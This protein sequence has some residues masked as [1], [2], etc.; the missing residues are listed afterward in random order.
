[1]HYW[2]D[3]PAQTASVNADRGWLSLGHIPNILRI[4]IR[5]EAVMATQTSKRRELH[6]HPEPLLLA[7]LETRIAP[8]ILP[9]TN[10]AR[11]SGDSTHFPV[12]Q[13]VSAQEA[14]RIVEETDEVLVAD[15]RGSLTPA[16][17]VARRVLVLLGSGSQG[18]LH[19]AVDRPRDIRKIPGGWQTAASGVRSLSPS[20]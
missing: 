5:I 4:L 14:G 6:E 16:Q 2:K 8:D 12:L 20:E 13:R 7:L 18:L 3:P 15:P 9:E 10:V 1:M 17:M 19:Q 11:C